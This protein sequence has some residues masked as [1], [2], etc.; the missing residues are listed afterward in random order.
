MMKM[1]INEPRNL[2]NSPRK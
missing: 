2:P 1:M